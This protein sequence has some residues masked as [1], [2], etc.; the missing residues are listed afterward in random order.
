MI[1]FSQFNGAKAPYQPFPSPSQDLSTPFI[2]GSDEII[3]TPPVYS[4]PHIGS[5]LIDVAPPQS[6]QPE[7]NPILSQLSPIPSM[8]APESKDLV[9][10]K[11]IGSTADSNPSGQDSGGIGGILG[12]LIL[13]GSGDESS[14]DASTQGEKQ[15][16]RKGAGNA[17]AA[18]A[19]D[20]ESAAA[21][22]MGAPG[23][24]GGSLIS[25][26]MKVMKVASG[27]GM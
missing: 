22:Y 5:Q 9:G 25:T 6:V 20:P 23:A 18:F 13:G 26:I 27:L 7:S 14:L 2:A 8:A 19:N 4:V 3:V 10:R 15:Q 11:P 1:D 21:S 12:R 16:K 17:S 24:G